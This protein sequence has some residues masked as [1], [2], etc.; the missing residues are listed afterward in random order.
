MLSSILRIVGSFSIAERLL[1]L[2]IPTAYA[3]EVSLAHGDPSA[4]STETY[5]WVFTYAAGGWLAAN[6]PALFKWRETDKEGRAKL[7]HSTY[8]SLFV[9]ILVFFTGRLL[10]ASDMG[11]FIAIAIAAYGGVRTMDALWERLVRVM[12]AVV[13]GVT[14]WVQSGGKKSD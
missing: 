8:V 7:I 4:V 6:M 11:T 2:A 13:N 14:S 10:K 12:D 1:F 5:L 3:A 9:G